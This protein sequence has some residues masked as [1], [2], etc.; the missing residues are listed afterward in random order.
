[1]DRSLPELTDFPETTGEELPTRVSARDA[2]AKHDH[3]NS[4]STDDNKDELAVTTTT[5]NKTRPRIRRTLT[6]DDGPSS[7]SSPTRSRSFKNPPRGVRRTNTMDGMSKMRTRSPAR[8]GRRMLDGDDDDE[9]HDPDDPIHKGF[10]AYHPSMMHASRIKKHPLGGGGGP[11]LSGHDGY[12]HHLMRTESIRT[13]DTS[14][15]DMHSSMSSVRSSATSSTMSSAASKQQM[16]SLMG[17][18]SLLKNNK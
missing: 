16:K 4:I 14:A 7:R 11:K 17:L 3:E 2:V 8:R 1:M 18:G 15:S 13:V 9:D 5:N 12:M 6:R 10:G